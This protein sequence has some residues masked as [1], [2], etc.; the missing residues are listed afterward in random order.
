MKRK[1]VSFISL[2]LALL[3][4]LPTTAFAASKAEKTYNNALD[5][6]ID[7]E[8]E[9]AVELFES[10]SS[11]EDA[12]QYALYA[13]SL[14]YGSEGK[15]DDALKTLD[16]LG[17]FKDSKQLVNYYKTCRLATST[18]LDD[19]FSAAS[20]FDQISAYRDSAARAEN[21][22]QR[23]YEEAEYRLKVK[24]YDTARWI[25]EKLGTYR[26]SVDQIDIVN[27]TELADAYAEAMSLK[28]AGKYED[29]I[30]AFTALD[31]YKD[32]KKQIEECTLALMEQIYQQALRD[33]ESGDYE[34]AYDLFKFLGSYKDS[35]EQ[36]ESAYE[37]YKAQKMKLADVGNTIFFGS[38]E[39]DNNT[40][41]G[42]EDIEWIV[43]AKED[44]KALLISKYAL[45][46]QKFNTKNE[47]VTWET[48]SLRNWLNNNFLNTAFSSDEQKM[49]STVTVTEDK[50]PSYRTDPGK[51]T[52]DKIFP[53]SIT[54]AEKYFASDADRAC[55]GTAYC[56]AQGAYKS[57][58]NGNC[59]WWLRSPGNYYQ[60]YAVYVEPSGL[61]YHAG[62]DVDLWN[63]A[64][65]PALWINLDS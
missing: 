64:V 20:R 4:M 62:V 42:K 63:R 16:F 26:D 60:N 3:F 43:L 27:E 61:V 56:Y 8:Y 21:C 58:S 14:L 11:Y 50:N 57:S 30:E 47:N 28:N 2:T 40:A 59:M 51:N 37:E 19:L 24:D 23:L 12:A 10:V 29:A 15:Y 18:Y 25:F 35:E 44:G 13:K 31:G 22:R 32:S 5:A 54:E 6:L 9:K 34:K 55:A 39:Q 49:I 7:G 17:D 33:K 53:L 65:R 1:T 38:Y 48:C 45:D 46:C 36:K 41:N 52:E